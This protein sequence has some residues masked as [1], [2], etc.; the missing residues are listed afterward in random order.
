MPSAWRL[1]FHLQHHC[2]TRQH[3]RAMHGQ[4]A[5]R[6][7]RWEMD[8]FAAVQPQADGSLAHKRVLRFTTATHHATAHL[9]K[10]PSIPAS[11]NVDTLDQ[12]NMPAAGLSPDG[13]LWHSWCHRA[14]RQSTPYGMGPMTPA[15]TTAPSS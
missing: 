12:T 4:E 10:P 8:M 3:A 11:V 1:T 13:S 14:G 6:W 9:L 5:G 15:Y 2:S 7:G